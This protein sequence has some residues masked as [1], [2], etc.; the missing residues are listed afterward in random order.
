MVYVSA[1]MGLVYTFFGPGINGV[2]KEGDKEGDKEDEEEEAGVPA[3]S[4]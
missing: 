2:E 3:A 1:S 4:L